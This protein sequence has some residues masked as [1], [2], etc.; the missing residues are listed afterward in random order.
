MQTYELKVLAL[1]AAR[2]C[3]GRSPGALTPNEGLL[4]A[5]SQGE[6]FLCIF[7]GTTP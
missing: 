7:E 5:R 1:R 3:K 2:G 6:F 4:S